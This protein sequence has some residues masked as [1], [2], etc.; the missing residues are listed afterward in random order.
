MQ[1]KNYALIGGGALFGMLF[2]LT[3]GISRAD[4]NTVIEVPAEWQVAANT[5]D[6]NRKP[7]ISMGE[8]SRQMEE[9]YNGRVTEIE[10]DR[11]WSGD[12]YE[13]EIQTADGYEWDVEM[14]AETGEILKEKRERDD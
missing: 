1:F 8:A 2:V 11:E 5:S 7:A 4:D 14:D 10:L 3:V 9:K 13:I 6:G 12:V